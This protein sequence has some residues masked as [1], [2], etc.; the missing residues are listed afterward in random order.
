[1]DSKNKLQTPP[2]LGA[3]IAPHFTNLTFVNTYPVNSKRILA[4]NDKYLKW[5]ENAEL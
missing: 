3:M 4:L 5:I 2:C 1:M